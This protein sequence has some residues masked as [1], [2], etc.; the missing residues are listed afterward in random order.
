MIRSA[1][2][3]FFSALSTSVLILTGC[4]STPTDGEPVVIS[5]AAPQPVA[6]TAP[7]TTPPAVVDVTDDSPTA[8]A[9]ASTTTSAEVASTQVNSLEPSTELSS[10]DLLF[11][12]YITEFTLMEKS[13][14]EQIRLGLSM[15]NALYRGQSK[16]DVT[17]D[18]RHDDRYTAPEVTNVLGA[19]TVSYCPEFA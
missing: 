8:R 4:S 13:E 9:R 12:S 17:A 5:R 19:A 18:Y 11:L 10:Q 16:S 7:H 15:C 2:L 1:R 6:A 3:G 14:S